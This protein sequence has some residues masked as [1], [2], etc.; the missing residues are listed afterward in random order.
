MWRHTETGPEL[1]LPPSLRRSQPCPHFDLGLPASR[2]VRPY[3]CFE[4]LQFVVLCY[5]SPRNPVHSAFWVFLRPAWRWST[6]E[7]PSLTRHVLTWHVFTAPWSPC[8]LCPPAPALFTGNPR[9]EGLYRWEA[10][11]LLVDQASS[12][13]W[14]SGNSNEWSGAGDL[15][16]EEG[17]K[18][19]EMS[20]GGR[21][22]SDW[23]R[24]GL[25]A[26]LLM[27]GDRGLYE[28]FIR[29]LVFSID[30]YFYLFKYAIQAQKCFGSPPKLPTQEN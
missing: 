26:A 2:T 7:R 19:I 1:I 11:P 14:T 23:G 20:P 9:N 5:G 22:H 3:F 6:K 29:S 25:W 30:I 4:G 17:D 15:A 8:L 16:G 18:H 28:S 24:A 13:L 27:N 21:G 12:Y 10:L